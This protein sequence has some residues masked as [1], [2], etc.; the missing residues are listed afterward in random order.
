LPLRV[1]VA[2]QLEQLQLDDQVLLGIFAHALDQLLRLVRGLVQ[3]VVGGPVLQELAGGPF[4]RVQALEKVV[5]VRDRVVKLLCKSWVLRQPSDRS[6]AGI[7]IGYQLIGIGDGRIQV[8][9][10]RFV[11]QELAGSAFTG[12]EIGGN[13]AELVDCRIQFGVERIV[14]DELA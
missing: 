9:I 3:V 6:L 10:H 2:R 12:V 8:V 13:R 14:V 7:D 4:T 1:A 11:F 5:E